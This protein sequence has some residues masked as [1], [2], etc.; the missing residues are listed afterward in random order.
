METQTTSASQFSRHSL[1]FTTCNI[2][3]GHFRQQTFTLKG[4]WLVSVE[5]K[6]CCYFWKAKSGRLVS[7]W[8]FDTRLVMAQFWALSSFKAVC[9][10]C[11]FLFIF[12]Q[13]R[14]Q[15]RA[16]FW[17]GR[18]PVPVLSIVVL[19]T[20]SAECMVVVNLR[21]SSGFSFCFYSWSGSV[22]CEHCMVHFI[23][24][25]SFSAKRGVAWTGRFREKKCV[26]WASV[27]LIYTRAIKTMK[28]VK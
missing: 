9:F 2:S 22:T 18:G 12:I 15:V 17:I 26:L 11:F 27:A 21:R 6:T 7:F 24:D 1:E 14:R 19:W 4:Q 5:S 8:F 13:K 20:E 28:K 25:V 3:Q 16:N 10:S 23:T